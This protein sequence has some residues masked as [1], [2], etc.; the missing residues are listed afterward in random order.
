MAAT[1][2]VAVADLSGPPGLTSL[3]LISAAVAVTVGLVGAATSTWT[4]KPG[5]GLVSEVTLTPF[6]RVQV[7]SCPAALQEKR[8]LPSCVLGL[9]NPR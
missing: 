2:V 6:D 5:A 3:L 8:L 1:R 7:T 9:V 4:A